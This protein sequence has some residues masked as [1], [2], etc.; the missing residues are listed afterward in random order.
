V[1]GGYSD[2]FE[3]LDAVSW[4]KKFFGSWDPELVHRTEQRATMSWGLDELRLG[5][6]HVDRFGRGY[7]TWRRPRVGG[8]CHWKAAI[9]RSMGLSQSYRIAGVL[10]TLG[11]TA[12]SAGH[13]MS[14][15]MSTMD[16]MWSWN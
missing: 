1:E 9:G 3:E 2:L 12:R 14:L 7:Q 15:P 16:R 8:V 6:S 13:W 11:G 5:S 10:P 4:M